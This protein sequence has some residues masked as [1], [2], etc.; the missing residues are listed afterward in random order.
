MQFVVADL[1]G[2]IEGAHEG[3]GLGHQF[4]RH[5]ERARVLVLLLAL[6][7]LSEHTPAEQERILLAA[8]GAYQPD[9]LQR[10][11]L[12]V[13]SHV[14]LQAPAVA[15]NAHPLAHVTREV[16]PKHAGLTAHQAHHTST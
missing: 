2:L 1:P 13:L 4:R 5:V 12:T 14:E 9:L 11:R 7:P 8:L 15:R 16:T 10:P 3:R 6:S